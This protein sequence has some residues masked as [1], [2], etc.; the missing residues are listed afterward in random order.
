MDI[1]T[2]ALAPVILTRLIIGRQSWLS[3]W[4]LVAVGLA[5][6]MPDL[7]NPHLSLEARHASWSHGLPFW[8]I[9]S[10]L[11]VAVT[12]FGKLAS[13]WKLALLISLAYLFH[14][15]CDAI[16]GGVDWF[17][18]VGHLLVG[19]YLVD[20]LYWVP[21]DVVL[22]LTAYYLFRLSPVLEK[23]RANRRM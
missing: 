1:F 21:L 16:S 18:P 22:F 15:V 9:F 7:L 23:A 12:R 14:M 20:P 10:V 6:A 11:A 13:S 17:Y 2:H 4:G 8:V 5:G 3:N 19:D